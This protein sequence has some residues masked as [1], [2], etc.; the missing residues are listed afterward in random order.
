MSVHC[1]RRISVVLQ[2]TCPRLLYVSA[3]FQTA[4]CHHTGDMPQAVY[5]SA[6]FQTDLC[7]HT[8]DMLQAVYVSSTVSDGSLQSYR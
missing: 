1:F 4:L 8:G 3:L 5:V 2:V 7:R 6:L